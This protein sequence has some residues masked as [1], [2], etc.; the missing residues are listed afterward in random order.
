MFSVAEFFPIGPRFEWIDLHIATAAYD[1]QG[2][3]TL[4][5]YRTITASI[6]DFTEFTY[7]TNVGDGGVREQVRGVRLMTR[8]QVAE[9]SVIWPP[10]TS[11]GDAYLA[12]PVSIE[13][14]M[15]FS[16][17]SYYAIMVPDAHFVDTPSGERM[18]AFSAA[19][20]RA[21][22]RLDSGVDLRVGT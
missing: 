12:Q 5:S 17:T 11:V 4:S 21:F 15:R 9:T 16:A 14:R 19:Y 22:D 7:G 20:S 18:G 10:G 6:V 8:D 1:D 3:R 13:K 2:A